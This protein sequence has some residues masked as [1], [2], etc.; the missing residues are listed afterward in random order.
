[1]AEP[2]KHGSWVLR[3]GGGCMSAP[4]APS[5]LQRR[6]W[7]LH[8]PIPSSSKGTLHWQRKSNCSKH[9]IFMNPHV[10]TSLHIVMSLL[11]TLGK[12][13]MPLF[14][15]PYFCIWSK[16]V[17]IY[18]VEMQISSNEVGTLSHPKSRD[19]GVQ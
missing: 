5:Y 1:M 12:S 13:V 18:H 16:D 8:A 6:V 7:W 10:M 9:S 2:E 11:R 15:S 19:K 14:F 4:Q 17:H 3:Q